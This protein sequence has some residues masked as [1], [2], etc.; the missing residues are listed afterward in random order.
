M[1]LEI[2]H[3]ATALKWITTLSSLLCGIIVF[4]IT[5]WDAPV[6]S[7]IFCSIF[8]GFAVLF[9][10]LLSIFPRTHYLFD[11]TGITSRNAK[12]KVRFFISWDKVKEINCSV[13]MFWV[14]PYF[15]GMSIKIEERMISV[16]MKFTEWHE[17]KKYMC[18]ISEKQYKQVL[19]AFNDVL[20]KYDIK[21]AQLR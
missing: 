13:G 5:I 16:D 18:A 9:F 7:L 20:Q 14:I 2:K 21:S 15:E 1:K 12:G 6:L 8:I 10:I 17:E 3:N 4:L 11:E 19:E